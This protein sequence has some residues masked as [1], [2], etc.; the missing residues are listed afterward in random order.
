MLL[1]ISNAHVMMVDTPLYSIYAVSL[2]SIGGAR[3]D[4]T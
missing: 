3:E 2:P 1:L 4:G